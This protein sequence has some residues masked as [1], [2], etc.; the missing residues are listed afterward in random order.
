MIDGK[1][2]P[3]VEAWQFAGTCLGLRVIIE[4]VTNTSSYEEIEVSFWT[5]AGGRQTKKIISYSAVATSRLIVV[6]T[7]EVIAFA[8]ATCSNREAS[9]VNQDEFAIVSMT[10]TRVVS[11]VYRASFVSWIMKAGGFEATP[12]EEMYEGKYEVSPDAPK[13]TPTSKITPAPA[14][15]ITPK[16]KP[17]DTPTITPTKTLVVAPVKVAISK[18]AV[19]FRKFLKDNIIPALFS[20]EELDKFRA[21]L[22]P[23]ASWS[24]DRI[25]AERVQLEGVVQNR[26]DWL[27]HEADK[28]NYV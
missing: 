3:N 5:K 21:E 9:K 10:Q 2:F 24:D 26:K 15:T 22:K 19:V 25:E 12:S 7:G 4:S 11:K 27:M 18:V 1:V 28:K 6:E 23:F 16:P 14:P 17:A 20:K 8:S 13:P